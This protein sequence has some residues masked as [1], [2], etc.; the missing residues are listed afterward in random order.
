[1]S[2]PQVHV[3]PAVVPVTDGV[4]TMV[5]SRQDVLAANPDGRIVAWTG[6]LT[7]GLV[8]AHT[9][10]QYTAFAEVGAVRYPSYIDW[11]Q[12]FVDEYDARRGEDWHAAARRGVDLALASGTTAFADVV[13]D[14]PA[15]DVL[16]RAG[17]AGVSYFEVIG[18]DE[19]AW[20][21]GVAAR[22]EQIVT[23]AETTDVTRVG[24]SPHAPYSLDEPV[25]PASA[26]LARRLG[27]RLH[28]HLAESDGEDAYYRS[29]TGALAERVAGRVGRR[30]GVLGRGGAGMG[31]GAFAEERRLLGPDSHM[32]HGVYLGEEGR[33]ILRERG[34][35]VALCP[36]SNLT[37]GIDTPPVAD[38]LR[39]GSPIAVGT[40]SLGSNSSLDL[41]EDLALLRQLAT[42]GGYTGD[43][44]DRRLL[45]A[46]TMG[47]AAAI[48]LENTIG[49][50]EVG[51]RADL[52]IF[53]VDPSLVRVERALVETAAGRCTGTV[54]AGNIRHRRQ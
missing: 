30:W 49:S 2:E 38:F 47:G 4:I 29:G 46:A 40:D 35:T 52:A 6:V 7:P 31:A 32:A 26:G 39:E 25:L 50:I 51:K 14:T 20:H 17:V 5:G 33:R 11:S 9:H 8:N 42:E 24:I 13:T 43:D 27:V 21:D 44:L 28:V 19:A 36:R 15:L 1:M 3:A 18:V 45:D 10:L 12:R 22:I 53:D 23:T 34:S 48:G 41:A 16:V 54:V 37:V